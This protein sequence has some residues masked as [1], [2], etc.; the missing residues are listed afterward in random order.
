[1]KIERY[2]TCGAVLR[3]NVAK[4][5]RDQALS[6]WYAAHCGDGHAR[7]DAATAEAARMGTSEGTGREARRAARQAQE[8]PQEPF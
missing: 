2:C 1:M 4:R 6:I 7:T 3:V 5:R 8:G